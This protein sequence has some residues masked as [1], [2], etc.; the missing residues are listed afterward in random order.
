MGRRKRSS[1]RVWV[2]GI[3]PEGHPLN[4]VL[5]GERPAQAL[6]TLLD[7]ALENAKLRD[8]VPHGH[9]LNSVMAGKKGLDAVPVLL[10]LALETLRARER[11]STGGGTQIFRGHSV[12]PQAGAVASVNR[13]QPI[14]K[15]L[16]NFRKRS[17]AGQSASPRDPQTLSPPP[18]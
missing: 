9:P 16:L 1:P 6:A 13:G 11:A 18:E 8:I 2:R 7:R 10:D 4:A 14:P 5:A 3:V 17:K 15:A 12:P